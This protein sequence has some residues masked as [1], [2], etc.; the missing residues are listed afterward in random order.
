MVTR[1]EIK[2]RLQDKLDREEEEEKVKAFYRKEIIEPAK[3]IRAEKIEDSKVPI[4][5]ITTKQEENAKKQ[6]LKTA[7]N[8]QEE[9]KQE[10]QPENKKIQWACD[11]GFINE[12]E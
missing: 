8:I 12:M 4:N 11:C 6:E 7:S 1:Y 3:K 9:Q 2:K 10:P 5:E